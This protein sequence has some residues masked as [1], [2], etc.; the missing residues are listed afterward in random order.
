MT[1]HGFL[2]AAMT[3]PN[4]TAFSRIEINDENYAARRVT[5][6]SFTAL[7]KYRVNGQINEQN[8]VDGV[9]TWIPN[10][11][12]GDMLYE[13]RYTVYKDFGTLKFPTVLHYHQGDR[14]LDRGHDALQVEVSDV[15]VN[16]DGP[17]LPVPEAVRQAT[18]AAARAESQRIAEGIWLI[19]GGSHNSVLVEFS[20]FVTVVEA[21]LDEGRS[22]AVIGEVKRLVPTKPIR[23]V[24][25][26]HH[27][28]DHSGGLRTYVAHGAMVITH[29]GNRDFYDRVAFSPAPRTLQPDLLSMFPR[30]TGLSQP[31]LIDTVPAGA[32]SGPGA[33]Q[34]FV[35]SDG[36]RAMELYP[37]QAL[38]H[39]GTMLMVYLPAERLLINA[40]L[41]SP[42]AQG[43]P[44]PAPTPS[45]RTLHQHL[46]R[47]KLDV[48]QHVPIHGSVGS[49]EAFLKIVANVGSN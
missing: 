44:P 31:P 10:P 36:K 41:Y 27:H 47:L 16:V 34:K 5:M 35:V 32:G 14:F 33:W 9:Q 26:T 25:N 15:Q 7:G 45:M 19:G 43:A 42:P 1:P 13:A 46:Q 38:N 18:V 17:S 37:L 12:L 21:P 30:R 2:K 11:V 23:Y 3:A 8:L 29:E 24:V 6:I 4:A 40:D 48:A 28:F 49:H 22:L 39:S 20:D